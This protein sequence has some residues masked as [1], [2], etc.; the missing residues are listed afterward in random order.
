MTWLW[1]ALVCWSTVAVAMAW[2]SLEEWE[3][4]RRAPAV[5]GLAYSLGASGLVVLIL[6]M[7][8]SRS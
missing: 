2:A 1:I 4:G 8:W 3:S 7:L 6:R 5:V